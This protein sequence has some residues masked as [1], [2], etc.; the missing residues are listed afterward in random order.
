MI[1]SVYYTYYKRP[2]RL[3]TSQT[4]IDQIVDEG[5]QVDDEITVLDVRSGT[6]SRTSC[7]RV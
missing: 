1:I 5:A 6:D 3:T 2:V 4:T 7:H